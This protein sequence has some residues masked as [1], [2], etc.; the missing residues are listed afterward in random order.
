MNRNKSNGNSIKNMKG[1][2]AV[3][4]PAQ[5]VR[6]P[7]RT[8]IPVPNEQYRRGISYNFVG[9]QDNPDLLR[10]ISEGIDDIVGQLKKK[11]GNDFQDTNI[12]ARLI[13]QHLT[14]LQTA[15]NLDVAT[16][17]NNDAEVPISLQPNNVGEYVATRQPAYYQNLVNQNS[18]YA[19]ANSGDFTNMDSANATARRFV[20]I[21]QGDENALIDIRYNYNID[22]TRNSI[23]N[24]LINCQNLEALYLI[25]HEELLT[26]FAFALNLFDKY[27]YAV[28]VILFLLKNLASKATVPGERPGGL[29][30]VED[31]FINM[32]KPL[33]K[34]ISKLVADQKKVQGIITKMKETI[35]EG[36]Q[37][38]GDRVAVDN[39][40]ANRL[41]GLIPTDH[42]P[43]QQPIQPSERMNQNLA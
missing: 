25:K 34:N 23:Q 1:G 38:F 4:A 14:G 7:D 11:L 20:N 16:I 37:K 36:K 5:Q 29:G 31:I 41:R 40:D 2:A 39:L 15:I 28:K 22:A 8:N 17:S 30:N 42:Q 32:P 35:F 12:N 24:R 6:P 3:P 19:K 33:I 18:E 43:G 9:A 27:K 26:T 13:M 10:I 21:I